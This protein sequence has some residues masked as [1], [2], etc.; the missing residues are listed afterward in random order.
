MW[1]RFQHLLGLLTAWLLADSFSS[2]WPGRKSSLLPD[3]G[4]QK[5]MP[6]TNYC[7]KTGHSNFVSCLWPG[8]IPAPQ[9]LVLV[10]HSMSCQGG[11]ASQPFTPAHLSFLGLCPWVWCCWLASWT[12]PGGR[13]LLT[14]VGILLW[15]L[16]F[17]MLV[18]FETG[19]QCVVGAGPELRSGGWPSI[20]GDSPVSASWVLRLNMRTM[21]DSE[22]TPCAVTQRVGLLEVFF[23][24]LFKLS[25]TSKAR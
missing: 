14:V 19:L 24:F 22:A 3:V 6:Y 11:T 13:L 18:C 8:P 23:F 25:L 2:A 17:C 10:S 12:S 9:M 1:F 20:W 16:H 7:L 15:W 21:L 5:R 4:P